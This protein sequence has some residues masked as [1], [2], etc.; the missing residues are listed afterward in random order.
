M[1]PY[2]MFGKMIFIFVNSSFT[3][4]TPPRYAAFR[5]ARACYVQLKNGTSKATA[6]VL[7]QGL[8]DTETC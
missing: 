6:R 2:S 5:I 3:L 1:I 8:K 4:E 7:A